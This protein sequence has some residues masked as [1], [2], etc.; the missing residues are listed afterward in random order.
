MFIVNP[1]GTLVYAGAID[2]KPSADPNDI[3]VPTTTCAACLDASMAGKPSPPQPPCRNG[4]SVKY[5]N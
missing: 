1:E 4:C 3:P 2:D 5:A